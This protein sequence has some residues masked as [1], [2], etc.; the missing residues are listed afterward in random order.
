MAREHRIEIVL[1]V[2][3]VLTASLGVRAAYI[4]L[5]YEQHVERAA[6]T[7][8]LS[9]G[10]PSKWFSAWSVG[11]GQAYAVIAADPS[12]VKLGREI[13]EPAYRFSRAGYSWLAAAVTLGKD[14][15]VPYGMAIAGGVSLLGVL[16]LA[17]SLRVRLGPRG[18][19]LILNPAIYMGFAGDTSEPLGVF[20]LALTLSTGSVFGAIALGVTRPTYLIGVLARRR[21]FIV[22]VLAAVLLAVYSLWR[23]GFEHFVPHGGRIDFPFFGYFQHPSLFGWLLAI[24]ATV[25]LTIGWRVRDWSWVVSGLFVLCFGHFVTEFSVNAWR[26]AGMLPVLWAFGPGYEIARLG[27]SVEESTAEA[28]V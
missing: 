20:L 16:L 10:E 24:V 14:R 15:L 4:P 2:V 23:F 8:D 26:A 27:E 6:Q 19:F 1:V 7:L 22:G 9:L 5:A 25:T 21:H 17:V 18:W 13:K 28:V 12:G 11:D 3:I